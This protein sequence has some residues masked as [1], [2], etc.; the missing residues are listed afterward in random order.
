VHGLPVSSPVRQASAAVVTR[1]V[2][3]DSPIDANP[4]SNF[5]AAGEDDEV[6]TYMNIE[7]SIL[8]HGVA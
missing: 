6:C 3:R 1:E 8:V 7:I 2:S 4:T 5:A